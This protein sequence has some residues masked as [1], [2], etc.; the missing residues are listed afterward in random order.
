MDPF[1]RLTIAVGEYQNIL[2][3][4]GKLLSL[5]RN[6]AVG[7]LS[8]VYVFKGPIRVTHGIHEDDLKIRTPVGSLVGQTR[9]KVIVVVHLVEVRPRKVN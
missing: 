7:S 2:V 1:A 9:I 4:T 5:S 6:P 8:N 3:N